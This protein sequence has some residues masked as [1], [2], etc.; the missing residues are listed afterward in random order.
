MEPGAK[1]GL[2]SSMHRTFF[3]LSQESALE[4]SE[5]IVN[6]GSKTTELKEGGNERGGTCLFYSVCVCVCV[7][8]CV[9]VFPQIFLAHMGE[10]ALGAAKGQWREKPLLIFATK[11]GALS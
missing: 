1:H 4:F 3:I 9:C 5:I 7:S 11:L 8:M 6:S 2:P 10:A